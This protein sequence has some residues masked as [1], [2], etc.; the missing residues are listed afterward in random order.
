[1][2]I[3]F[4]AYAGDCRV[5]GHV[6]LTGERLTDMLNDSPSLR[7]RDVLLESLEDGRLLELADMELHRDEVFAVEAVGPRGEA[8]RRL[9]TRSHRMQVSLGPYLVM[10]Q[11]HTMPGAD[12]MNSILRRDPMVPLTNATIG[13]T[14]SGQTMMRDV[15]TLIVNR[16]LADWINPAAGEHLAFPDT[17]ILTPAPGDYY[18]KDLTGSF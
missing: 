8:S 1:V 15:E 10:G 18:A 14:I 13:Y 16:E 9:R 11:L 5:A 2:Q 6:E 3:E 17:P 4:M 12:P 7:L